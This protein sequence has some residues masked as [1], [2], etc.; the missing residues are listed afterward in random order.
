MFNDSIQT[1]MR[2]YLAA[3]LMALFLGHN[4]ILACGIEISYN[5]YL[6]DVLD[7]SFCH[8][9]QIQERCN[10]FWKEYTGGKV[11]N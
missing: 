9:R 8:D 11:T 1:T 3:I 2:K 5:Y 10:V 7:G 6:F 4:D